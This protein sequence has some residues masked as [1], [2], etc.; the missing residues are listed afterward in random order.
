VPFFFGILGQFMTKL[1]SI[2]EVEK[3]FGFKKR[4]LY[5]M[6]AT[7]QLPVVRIQKKLYLKPEDLDKLI[8]SNYENYEND[9][10][11]HD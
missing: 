7:R 8:E 4:T 2:I 11:E 9:G 3:I 5:Y 6:I 10:P 1:L